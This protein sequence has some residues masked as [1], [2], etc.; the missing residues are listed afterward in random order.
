MYNWLNGTP[1]FNLYRHN[2]PYLYIREN[3]GEFL[4]LEN[5]ETTL[6]MLDQLRQ[7]ELDATRRRVRVINR[8]P[9]AVDVAL[10]YP[11]DT[12]DNV[13]YHIRYNLGVGDLVDLF[14]KSAPPEGPIIIEFRPAT[15]GHFFLTAPVEPG[16]PEPYVFNPLDLPGPLVITR[17]HDALFLSY[18]NLAPRPL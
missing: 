12:T 14:A 16:F 17:Q 5:F 7:Q 6:G 2:D 13:R 15:R 18:N 3:P 4:P 1:Y 10:R 11:N 8:G 9:N